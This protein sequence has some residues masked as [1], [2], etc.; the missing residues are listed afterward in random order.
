VDPS[1]SP[2]AR[3][4]RRFSAL[5]LMLTLALSALALGPGFQRQRRVGS[6]FGDQWEPALAADGY[7]HVYILY[8]QYTVVPDCSGCHL[9]SMT[10]LISNNGGLDWLA[11]RR[12]ADSYSGQF[13]PQIV[14]DPGDRRT[15]YAAWLENQKH[16]VMIAKSVDFGQSWSVAVAVHTTTEFDKPVLAVR[17]PDVYLG[18]SQ[19]HTLQAAA[20][21]DGG[22]TF[23]R[24]QIQSSDLFRSS[25]L[26]GATVDPAGNAYF[27]WT[28][29][30]HIGASAALFVSKSEG[31]GKTWSSTAL[32][33]SAAPPDCENKKCGWSYLGAQ[34]VIASDDAGTLYALWN[35]GRV[36]GGPERVYFASSTTGGE[37]WSPRMSV[38]KAAARVEHAFPAITAGSPGDVRIAWMDTR[39]RPL[40]NTYYRSS[41]NGGASWSPET[42]LSSFVPGYSY[43][44]RQG[45][46]FPFG[47]YFELAIDGLSQTHAVW[48]EGL[49]YD[50][51]G[52]IWYTD[53]R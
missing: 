48:G 38:S 9:P 23:L 40:W 3:H 45:F 24:S 21:H 12:I 42:K 29:Y 34:I 7:D 49:N 4:F 36:S 51:P 18:F 32:D 39:K 53:G 2:F 14:V 8:P 50:S 25:L 31:G 22:V 19:G 26:S 28:G 43:V 17:G 41:T 33:L 1:F 6:S 15:V 35:S 27:A 30:P 11:P 37:T 20:S 52:S 47:D 46:S 5:L 16:D 44:R 13:D 10:L